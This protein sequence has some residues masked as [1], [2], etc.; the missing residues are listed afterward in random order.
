LQSY[1]FFREV[2][3]VSL[4]F[5]IFAD[6]IAIC[7]SITLSHISKSFGKKLILKD[8][9]FEIRPGQITG[10]LGPNGAG[11]STCMRIITGALHPDKGSIML[12][13]FSLDKQP[14]EARRQFGYLPENNPLYET[15]QVEEYLTFVAHFYYKELPTIKQAVDKMLVDLSLTDVTYQVI[16][17][18]S[19]GYR[20]RVGIAQAL[21]PDPPI[22]ILDEPFGGLDPNQQ[23]DVLQL[24]SKLGVKKTILFS[25]HI[26]SEIEAICQRVIIIHQGEI[27]ADA[28]LQEIEKEKSL[29][30]VFKTLTK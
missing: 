23:E 25:S 30:Q 26:L 27:K 4:L 6:E 14:L 3:T 2:A 10:F 7:M 22:I 21:L 11:K 17:T 5:C 13:H 19:K 8:V 1:T 12:N 29:E 15:M 9:S 20:Q 18:L 28:P 16:A 24:I